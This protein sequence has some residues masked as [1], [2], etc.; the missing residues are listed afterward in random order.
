VTAGD[1]AEAADAIAR[2]L[3]APEATRAMTGAAR[4]QVVTHY[5]LPTNARRLAAELLPLLT[6]EPM[7]DTATSAP[8]PS[9]AT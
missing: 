5:D 2:V 8:A 1:V 3:T 4:G 6:A 9:G 7:P